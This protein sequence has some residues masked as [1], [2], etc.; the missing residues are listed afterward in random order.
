MLIPDHQ[1]GMTQPSS[2]A[3]STPNANPAADATSAVKLDPLKVSPIWPLGTPLSMLLY[4]STVAD[5]SDLDITKPAVVWDDLTFGDYKDVRE[6][7]LTLN[8][9]QSVRANNGSWWMDIILVKGGG[10]DFVGKG[11]E[12]VALYRKGESENMCRAQ[13]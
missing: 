10:I 6:A 5:S 13:C 11:R 12:E 8:V 9:P 7:D 2:P 3:P 1:L 4:T